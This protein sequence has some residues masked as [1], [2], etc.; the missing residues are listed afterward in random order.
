MA[1]GGAAFLFALR[2]IQPPLALGLGAL[3]LGLQCGQLA[4]KAAGFR[5]HGGTLLVVEQFHAVGAGLELIELLFGLAGLF[6]HPLR[7]QAVD[8]GAGEFF[9]QFGIG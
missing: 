2:H 1:G 3:L 8:V 4:I 7:N 5:V 6:I 9:Q